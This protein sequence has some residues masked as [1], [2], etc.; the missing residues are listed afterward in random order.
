MDPYVYPGT[1][2]LKNKLGITDGAK[3][4]RVEIAVTGR[5]CALLLEDPIRGEFDFDHL[6]RIH[7]FMFQDLF[8]WAG[9]PRTCDLS[10]GSTLFCL[11]QYINSY[12]SSE[13]FPAFREKCLSAA[14]DKGMFV[15]A[16][17]ECYADL[18]M[19]HPFREGNGRTQREFARE[20]CL[21]CGY[22]FDLQVTSH[23][24]MVAASIAAVDGDNS[25]L[26]REFEAA[27]APLEQ[28]EDIARDGIAKLPIFTPDDISAKEYPQYQGPDRERE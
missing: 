19:L 27:I 5:R 28:V 21:G 10:K 23:E 4:F 6:K 13:V 11:P 25:L 26:R 7:E 1:T 20:L 16:F 12:A 3:L 2:V 17:T 24:K 18:N 15:D 22:L 9:Q 14:G 8:D